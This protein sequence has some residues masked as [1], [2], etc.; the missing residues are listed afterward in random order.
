MPRQRIEHMIIE[1]K[2][3]ADIRNTRTTSQAS[4]QY[5]FP[6][7]CGECVTGVLTWAAPLCS[8]MHT[9][10]VRQKKSRYDVIVDVEDQ[11]YSF[12]HHLPCPL[13]LLRKCCRRMFYVSYLNWS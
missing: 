12:W 2:S 7:S 5:R 13:Q 4:D 1:A 10:L 8:G 6:W 3:G 11:E 9:G